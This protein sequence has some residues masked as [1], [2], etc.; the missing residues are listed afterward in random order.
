M[1]KYLD[2]TKTID[3]RGLF[4]FEPLNCI[5]EII[6]E[7][8]KDTNGVLTLITKINSNVRKGDESLDVYDNYTIEIYPSKKV[9]LQ[10]KENGGYDFKIIIKVIV[11][12]NESILV[13]EV[14]F[15]KEKKKYLI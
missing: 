1:T 5:P 2:Y 8:E 9:I 11:S 14:I 6:N 3:E 7:I 15:D 4:N 12:G 10:L 13:E